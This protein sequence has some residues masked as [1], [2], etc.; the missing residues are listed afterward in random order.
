MLT[1][2]QRDALKAIDDHI[3][4]YGV[5]PTFRQ[6]AARLRIVSICSIHRLVKGLAERGHITN[7]PYA[8]IQRTHF[9]RFN[10][11]TKTLDRWG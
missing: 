9:Y 8:P 10:D 11:E 4:D 2:R 1:H 6:L 7:R 3:A 5:T